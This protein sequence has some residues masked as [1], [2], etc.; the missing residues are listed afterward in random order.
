MFVAGL[1]VNCGRVIR[2][3]PVGFE[4]ALPKY[5]GCC[6]SSAFS[7]T[8]TAGG[9]RFCRFFPLQFLKL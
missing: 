9:L 2:N 1:I 4:A 6:L 5:S 8:H 7:I 3:T